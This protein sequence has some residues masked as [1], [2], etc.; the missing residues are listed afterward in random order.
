MQALNN[1]QNCPLKESVEVAQEIL[2]LL[3]W[4]LSIIKKE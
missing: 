1:I 4:L 2:Q 3:Y